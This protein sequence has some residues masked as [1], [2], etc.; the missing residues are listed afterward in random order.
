MEMIKLTHI[1]K[2]DEKMICKK[3]AAFLKK[4]YP[5]YFEIKHYGNGASSSPTFKMTQRDETQ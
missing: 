1:I 4:E 2:L 3:V 5:Y